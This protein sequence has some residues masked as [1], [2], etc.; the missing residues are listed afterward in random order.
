[1]EKEFT[2]SD[3]IEF[4]S[5]FS[6]DIISEEGINRFRE[7]LRQKAEKEYQLYLELKAKY[8]N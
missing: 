4:A 1:M 2:A 3:M 6:D 5:W 7:V 8:E